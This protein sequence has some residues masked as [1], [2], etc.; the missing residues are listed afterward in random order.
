MSFIYSFKSPIS[1]TS[2]WLYPSLISTLMKF[3]TG[4]SRPLPKKIV[5]RLKMTCKQVDTVRFLETRQPFWFIRANS[6][7][8]YMFAPSKT[9]ARLGFQEPKG[10][11][12][13]FPLQNMKWNFL[14]TMTFLRWKPH[15]VK[16]L[17]HIS[18]SLAISPVIKLLKIHQELFS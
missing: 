11:F 16:N 4:I 10:R 3:G 17:N 5:S 12:Q 15:L 6:T 7:R 9:N 2:H 18:S 1:F 8:F 13:Y 14:L